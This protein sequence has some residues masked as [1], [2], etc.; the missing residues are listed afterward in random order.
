MKK[1][2]VA[3]AGNPNAGKTTIFNA[4][5]GAHQHVGNW[6]GVTV[7]KK[8]GLVRHSGH[9]IRVVDLPGTYSLTAYSLEEIIARNFIVENRPDVVVNVVDASNLERNLYLAVQLLEMDT[10][11]VIALNMIDVAQGR[12]IQIDTKSLSEL[13]GVPVIPTDGKRRVGIEDLLEAAVRAAEAAREP[14]GRKN[15]SYGTE[16]E[17]ELEKIQQRLTR[18]GAGLDG[19]SHRWLS[20]KLLEGDSDIAAK[21]KGKEDL[22]QVFQQVRESRRHLAE[23]FDD[24]PEIILTD[25][26]YGFISGAV[27][28]SVELEGADRVHLSETIDK[29][30]THRLL[31]PIILILIIYLIYSF[32]FQGSDPLVK[33]MDAAFK[34]LGSLMAA[35]MPEGLLRSLVVSGIIDGVGG[36]LGF[37]PL[38]AFMFLAIAILED[39]GYMARIAFMMDRVCGASA[40]TARL[41]WL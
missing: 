20:V 9:E 10:R 34:W 33:G 31:G 3:L 15:V 18:T 36:V 1:I 26:R 25:A 22:D 24:S 38:I 19:L 6:P 21:I 35:W 13:L 30:L 40:C 14:D 41:C 11:L 17:E 29:V 37:T 2:T 32:I 39:T 5:T 23:I 28:Q 16:V 4:I 12:R 27:R 7:E 8:E